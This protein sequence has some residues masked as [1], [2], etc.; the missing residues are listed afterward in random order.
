MIG[1]LNSQSLDGFTD[2]Q[3]RGFRQGLKE[4]VAIGEGE[5]VAIKYRWAEKPKRPSA[6]VAAADLVPA[7]DGWP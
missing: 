7:G 1:F 6:G 5:N 2:G 3:L 4:A